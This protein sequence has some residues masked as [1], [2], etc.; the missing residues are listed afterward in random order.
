MSSFAAQ[1]FAF[2]AHAELK[3][4]QALRKSA[5][6]VFSRVIMRTPVDTGRLR[7][8]WQATTHKQATGVVEE[9]DQ[10][11]PVTQNGSGNSAAKRDMETVVLGESRPTVFHLSNTLPYAQVVEYGSSDQ[12]PQGMV[13]ISVLEFEKIVGEVTK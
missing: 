8:N 13:R 7:G 11:G 2:G 9:L 3:Q 6:E 4:Q 1:I 5:F 12:A 10:S